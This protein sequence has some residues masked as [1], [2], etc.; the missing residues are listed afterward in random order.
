MRGRRR[1][2]QPFVWLGTNALAIYA[3]SEV[4]RRLL[5]AAVVPQTVGLTTPKAW[6]FWGVLEPAFR[7]WPEIG[8]LLFAIG[9]LASVDGGCEVLASV[10]LKPDT[11]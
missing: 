1:W 3:G 7:S 6:L 10:R 8:S 5:D 9:V 2:C 4:V 11:T